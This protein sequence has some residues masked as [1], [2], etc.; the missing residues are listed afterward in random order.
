MAPRQAKL[1][2][3][4]SPVLCRPGQACL[5]VPPSPRSP[6]HPATGKPA[7][8]C[9]PGLPSEGQRCPPKG[10]PGSAA[11]ASTL[12]TG[13][14]NAAQP[15]RNTPRSHQCGADGAASPPGLLEVPEWAPGLRAAEGH[16]E[17][18]PTPAHQRGGGTGPPSLPEITWGKRCPFG[19]ILSLLGGECGPGHRGKPTGLSRE[20]V[21]RDRGCFACGTRGG[22][23]PPRVGCGS[24]GPHGGL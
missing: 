12:T 24:S 3:A 9:R 7:S 23:G 16:Q 10:G 2:A 21:I 18:S 20:P 8:G 19:T 22:G 6:E 13:H 4:E 11:W 15:C 1:C 17:P 5:L 14:R